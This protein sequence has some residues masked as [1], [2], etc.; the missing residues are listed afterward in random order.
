MD[1]LATPGSS[2]Y[3]QVNQPARALART[4]TRSRA[5][6]RQSLCLLSPAPAPAPLQLALRFVLSLLLLLNH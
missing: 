6:R 4:L 5:P 3:Q 2:V 1:H